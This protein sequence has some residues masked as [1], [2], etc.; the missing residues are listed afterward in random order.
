MA[1]P[2]R[3]AINQ[4]TNRLKWG[5]REAIA[6]YAAEGVRGIGVWRDKLEQCG[7]SEARALL[8]GNG[9]TVTSLHR[10]GKFTAHDPE[11]HRAAI[12]DGRWAVD[13][14]AAINAKCLALV[15]GGLPPRSN[16]LAGARERVR[17]GI[18]ELLGYAR[19]A[20]VPLA[21]EPQ[22]PMFAAD[23]A[24]INT[25]AHANDLCDELG[26][27]VGVVIDAY[28]LWWERDL[29]VE[30]A[31]AG[32]KRILAFQVSD[33]LVPTKHFMLDRGMMGD[34]VIDL[35]RIRGLIEDT[36]YDGFHEVEI[37]SAADWWQRDQADVVRTCI[38]RHASHV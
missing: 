24:C 3:L 9:M 32:R 20:S 30:I 2:K 8:D 18:G 6:G 38:E 11:H 7:V 21:I 36:G 26:D 1:D 23:R 15:V 13:L 14:A 5:L 12:E 35:R 16:D 4:T 28:H 19:A 25:L 22:H 27:G 29:D 17:D 33:W 37:L 31:R 34:G 10:A